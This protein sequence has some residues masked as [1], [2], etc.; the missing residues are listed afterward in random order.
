[1]KTALLLLFAFSAPAV[2]V[3]GL[4]WM[5]GCWA[6][7]Q[8]ALAIEEH[9]TR[10]AAGQ[11]MGVARTIRSGKVIQHEFLLIDTDSEGAFYLPR[12]SNG[13]EPVKFRLTTQ[14]A[15]RAVFENP[16]H[17]FP[18]RILYRKTEGGL[19]ARIE[20]KQ[21]GRDRAVDF[22]MKAVPCN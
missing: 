7:E 2:D 18:Q 15:S 4:S 16:A 8:G 9:W 11:M 14:S 17:D 12:I 20:G 13:D 5:S 21:N 10:P 22:P 1:M 3:A 6:G 19:F